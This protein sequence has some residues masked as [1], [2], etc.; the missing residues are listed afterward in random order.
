MK[1]NLKT[2]TCQYIKGDI[3]NIA[4]DTVFNKTIRD[5]AIIIPHVC[6]NVGV[7]GGG[8]AKDVANHYPIVRENFIALGTKYSK[9]GR[10]Q[11]IEVH[12]N[13]EQ[14]NKLIIANMIA[15]NGTISVSNPRPLN[16]NALVYCM[17]DINRYIDN[18]VSNNID[19]IYIHCPRFGSGLAGGNWLFIQDLI[20]DVWSKH[21]VYVYTKQHS[22]I[23]D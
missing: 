14:K 6:N 7:F 18:L 4:K 23:K 19:K 8:F 13:N 2:N 3:F 17:N 15:Q 21:I 16:Y 1:Q 5:T 9:L 12:N 22:K 20:N 11:Y 10:V